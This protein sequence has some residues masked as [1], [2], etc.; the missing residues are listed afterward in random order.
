M[1]VSTKYRDRRIKPLTALDIMIGEEVD[2]GAYLADDPE[3]FVLGVPTSTGFAYECHNLTALRTQWTMDPYPLDA[4]DPLT[5]FIEC[6]ATKFPRKP[7]PGGRVFVKMGFNNMM[8]LKP[9]WV[10]WGP[11]PEPR[12]FTLQPAGSIHYFISTRMVPTPLG[13]LS[14][15]N[16]QEA[17]G[18]DDCNQTKPTPYF[19][20][21][22]A[23]PEVLYESDTEVD[24][25]EGGAAEWWDG[26]TP[27]RQRRMASASGARAASEEDE[28]EIVELPWG[29]RGNKKGKRDDKKRDDDDDVIDLTG[30]YVVNRATMFG[31]RRL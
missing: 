13:D 11:V 27:K 23:E 6:A 29:K 26:Y 21:V 10:F 24:E 3:N 17:L 25:E 2:V 8:V 7:K 15:P 20:L 18:V 14:D 9:Q 16:N 31:V 28:E 22:A 1:P 12:V 30:G 5:V 4:R 19:K